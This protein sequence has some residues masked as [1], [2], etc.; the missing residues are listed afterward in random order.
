MT[1]GQAVPQVSQVASAVHR[2]TGGVANFY[3]IGEG[4]RFILVDAGTPGDWG[5]LQR[6]LSAQ[7]G[8]LDALEAVVLTHAHADH[9]GFAE[10]A[11]TEAHAPVWVHEAD[12]AVAKGAKP[13]KNDGSMVR[14]LLRAEF[15]R[16]ALSLTRRGGAKIVPVVEVSAYGDG[17]V[18]DLPGRPRTIHTPGH[19][20]G[21]AALFLGGRRVLLSGDA[22]VTRNPLTGRT[23]PQ[24]MP[25]GFN[26]D[27]TQALNSLDTLKGLS[28]DVILPGHGEPWTGGTDEAVRQAH[29][30]GP[31]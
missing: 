17:E 31:S 6:A 14:Y 27:T 9:T 2:V 26:R 25:S 21:N 20:P 11:R 1:A 13:G 22:M 12:A 16:T 15:Y 10:R 4:G 24:I 18:L 29:A 19:T 3:L 7:G 23:G 28:A 5:L 30:A 8:V